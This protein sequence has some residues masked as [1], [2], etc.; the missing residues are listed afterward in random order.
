MFRGDLDITSLHVWSDLGI[1]SGYAV[2]AKNRFVM[3]IRES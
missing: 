1:T 3:I 2:L